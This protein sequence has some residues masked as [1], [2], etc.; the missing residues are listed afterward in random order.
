MTSI[1]RTITL[2]KSPVV[3]TTPEVAAPQLRRVI[4]ALW[5]L[6]ENPGDR[7]AKIAL[8]L[9]E[10]QG[11]T[12]CPCCGARFDVAAF[13]ATRTSFVEREALVCASCTT[14]FVVEERQTV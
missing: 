9:L 10:K 14:S 2:E 12:A 5:A 7:R 13:R 3:V 6:A 11:A 4:D 1:K 8:A